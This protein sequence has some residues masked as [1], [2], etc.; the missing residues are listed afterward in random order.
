MTTELAEWSRRAR[1]S[2]EPYGWREIAERYL[3]LAED[4]VA[5]RAR[6]GSA[7]PVARGDG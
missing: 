7:H 5:E 4:L 3:E 6:G 2:V 1:E